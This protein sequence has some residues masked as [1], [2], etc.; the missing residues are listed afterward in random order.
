MTRPIHGG[1][2][3][4]AA[5]LAGRT[6]SLILDFSASISPLGPP[7]S[8]LE[9]IQSALTG[10]NSYPD[11]GY[12]TF[13]ETLGEVLSLDP[14]WILPG[15]GSAELL[16]WA[17]L[18]LSSLTGTVLLT[19]AF[20]DYERALGTFGV[21]VLR[22]PLLIEKDQ[23]FFPW[24]RLGKTVGKNQLGLLFNNPHN[25][26]GLLGNRR[27]LVS[28]LSDF[29]LVVIDEAFMDFLPPCQE[30]SLL[31]LVRESPNLVI[32]RSLT[33]FYALPGLRLGYAIAHPDR[34]LRWQQWRD[35]WP[36]NILAEAAA[37]AVLRDTQFSANMWDWLEKARWQLWQGL[38]QLPG[39]IPYRGTANFLLVKSTVSVTILQKLLLQNHGILIRDCLSFPELGDHYFRIA[40][41]TSLENDRLL[42]AL[43][44][45][46]NLIN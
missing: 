11:P 8:A 35:P 21:N 32:L 13:R 3:G 40:V 20:G 45:V 29:A 28:L 41:R 14:D 36:V 43:N 4:W 2:L 31:S 37:L 7:E 44:Q 42:T 6:P 26:T 17:A 39:L 24:E 10:L 5:T 22:Y 18:D 12:V 27:E 46:L 38:C 9:A 25:P 1:N 19:P 33:K 23:W 30:Q 34:L 16:T 15:N